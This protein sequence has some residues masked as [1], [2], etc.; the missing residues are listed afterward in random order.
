[1]NLTM[2]LREVHY[3]IYT[4]SPAAPH[5]YLTYLKELKKKKKAQPTYSHSFRTYI[6]STQ[7]EARLAVS[8]EKCRCAAIGLVHARIPDVSRMNWTAERSKD[9]EF[10]RCWRHQDCR[11]CLGESGCAWCPFV[12]SP[13]HRTLLG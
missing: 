12:I 8:S 1:M 9:D 7:L 10:L 4:K 6:R 2:L 5:W 11:G 13:I 3:S